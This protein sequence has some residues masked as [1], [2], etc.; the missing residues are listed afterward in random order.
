MPR[1][2]LMPD[3]RE[4]YRRFLARKAPLAKAIGIEPGEPIGPLFPFQRHCVD[5]ALRQG[6]A[7]L[8]LSTGLGKT[9]CEL[10]FA[11]Q[12]A[13]ATNGRALIL[14][15]LAVAWQIAA[16]GQRF[17]YDARVIRDQSE[18]RAGIN[19][20]N[21]D[22]LDKLDARGF[23]AVVLDE[24]SILKGFDG[25][26]SRA[27]IEAFAGHRFKLS[28]TATPA[29]N[30]HMELGQQSTFLNQMSSTEM[31]SRYFVNDTSNASQKWR[32]KG[33]AVA[34]FWDW[35]A[36]WSRCATLPSDLGDFSDDGFILPPL[37]VHYHKVATKTVKPKDGELFAASV[38][39]TTMFDIKR[40]TAADRAR[41]IAGIV[42]NSADPWVIWC[43]TDNEADHL[44]REIECAVEVRGPHSPEIK[45]DRLRAFA[46]GDARVLVTKPSICGWGLNWQHCANVAFVGRTFSYEQYFQAV[47]RCWRF[48]QK[49]QV[50]VHIAIGE[51]E[52]LIASAVDRKSDDHEKM[53]LEMTAAMARNRNA[54]VNVKTA[55]NPTFKGGLPSWL[56]V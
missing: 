4:K 28:A 52:D 48:G 45:E 12:A 47:R 2:E 1:G 6:R 42:L 14:T 8:F 56:N 23:G 54:D 11:R 43:D 36:S 49:R 31:L 27:L 16:E 25:A 5:F 50:N 30:D 19:I 53:R 26:T 32:I 7:A 9:I 46:S 21:Y 35:V 40:Q 34:S 13:E 41:L 18:A 15:P 51:G 38:S 22:R 24:S 3:F 37:K 20:C 10:E 29:P 39:A 55:Y 33:H 17:G 44:C